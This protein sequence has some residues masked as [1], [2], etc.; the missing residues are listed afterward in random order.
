MHL[1]TKVVLLASLLL[2]AA[3]DATQTAKQTARV[4]FNEPLTLREADAFALEHGVT[5]TQLV[6][7][8]KVNGE[9]IVGF[10]P[11]EGEQSAS[12][13]AET[14][15]ATYRGFVRDM[16]YASSEVETASLETPPLDIISATLS[17]QPGSR[18]ASLES[19]ASVAAVSL[20]SL[21]EAPLPSSSPPDPDAGVGAQ[22]WED[23]SP[24][25]GRIYVQPSTYGTGNRFVTNYMSWYEN[26]FGA[27]HGYEHDFFLNNSEQSSLGPGTYLSRER[28]GTYP[29][30]E[31]ASTS[32][33]ASSKPYLDT[34]FQDGDV[35]ISYTIGMVHAD[36]I[37]ANDRE[38]FTYIRVKEGDADQDNAKLVAKR[39]TRN[40]LVCPRNPDQWCMF[41]SESQEIFPAWQ[42]PIPLRKEWG[43]A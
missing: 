18:V 17:V 14:W 29:E 36:E 8:Y 25:L 9:D 24:T 35:E 5:F 32:W 30:V 20:V 27:D 23:W 16:G 40:R 38:Y 6:H 34:R 2:L 28:D 31:Y 12:S 26:K 10:L 41:E 21:P 4:E 19:D 1:K 33:P 37:A 43:F 22:Y 13:V 15:P 42:L 3:C 11:L 7:T 39:T